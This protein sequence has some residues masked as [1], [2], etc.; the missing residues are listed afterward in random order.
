MLA[1]V[2]AKDACCDKSSYYKRATLTEKQLRSYDKDF[3]SLLVK[4]SS[5]VDTGS[6]PTATKRLCQVS[7]VQEGLFLS[8]INKVCRTTV[9]RKYGVL[10]RLRVLY[11]TVVYLCVPCPY[12]SDHVV[13]MVSGE[14]Y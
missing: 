8:V 12:V 13:A 9:F 6:C 3:Y 2:W 10:H 14:L 1:A 11:N 7:E 4:L 5:T